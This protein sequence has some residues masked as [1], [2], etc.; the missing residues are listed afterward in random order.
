MTSGID[1][2]R[3][4]WA[5]AT[6]DRARPSRRLDPAPG[7]ADR[8]GYDPGRWDGAPSSKLPPDCPVKPLGRDGEVYWFLDAMSQ[9]N[10]VHR[11]KW[12]KK[13]LLDLFAGRQWYLEHHWPRWRAP[14]AKEDKPSLN[15][16]EVDSVVA[17]LINACAQIGAVEIDARVH[18]RGAWALGA[19]GTAQRL[20]WHA[21]DALY[22]IHDGRLKSAPPCAIKGIVYPGGAPILAPWPEEVTVDAAG[23]AAAI[24]EDFR[25]WNYAKPLLDPVMLVGAIGCGLLGGALDWRPYGFLVGGAGTG[26]STLQNYIRAV[27]DD[28]MIKG[29]NVTEAS[30]RQFGMRDSLPISID[31]FEAEKD[32]RKTEAVLGLA[33][34]AASGDDIL[35]GGA[36]HRASRF[37]I[38]S[39]FLFSAINAPPMNAA[40]RSRMALVAL[41]R[42]DPTK[43]R[44]APVVRPNVGRK[45]LRLLMQQWPL[46]PDTLTRWRDVL[47]AQAF[48]DRAQM[49]YGTLLAI[50]ELMLGEVE[51]L[52]HGLDIRDPE[53]IGAEL[54]A[55]TE[56][57]REAQ[58]DNWAECV[59]LL[60]A[61]PIDA[62][63][64]GRR[65]TVGG[66]L[67]DWEHDVLTTAEANDRLRLV[68]LAVCERRDGSKIYRY[69]AV[70]NGVAL[71]PAKILQDTKFR[72][73]V[74]NGALRQ[75]PDPVVMSTGSWTIVRVNR[76]STRCQLLDLG[77]FDIWQRENGLVVDLAA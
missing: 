31:E 36:D 32:N 39:S 21:G 30:L 15:G 17:C 47:R 18:G 74:W 49:T 54:A 26:K 70:P 43:P 10:G 5:L 59:D 13:I 77:G 3:E 57:A 27:W 60:L 51:L 72:D 7:D 4:T 46:L 48:S 73:G 69:L 58:A 42:V 16:V 2:I 28:A 63:K 44:S 56:E 6:E 64:D 9:L 19:P 8:W 24:L 53:S 35:R 45:I 62:W 34:V 61:A 14:G 65:P 68:G 29:S 25:S 11:D 33:R 37:T 50:A 12:G 1:R 67:D 20:V 71:G 55:Y 76:V 75:A 22:A 23:P 40:D 41:R 66:V 52:A 38:R